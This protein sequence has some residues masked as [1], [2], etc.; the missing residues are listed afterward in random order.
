MVVK[1]LGHRTYAHSAL[2]NSPAPSV[3]SV[4]SEDEVDGGS[5][6]MEMRKWLVEWYCSGRTRLCVTGQ[7]VFTRSCPVWVVA[8]TLYDNSRVARRARVHFLVH[9][10]LMPCVQT[11]V[12]VKT[13]VSFTPS[14]S[15]GLCHTS[16]HYG[17]PWTVKRFHSNIGFVS[18][19]DVEISH[20]VL[21]I[22]GALRKDT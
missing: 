4:G 15:P 3:A 18:V 16:C 17:R 20:G 1:L 12:S 11:L 6:G 2:L 9:H 8:Y 7:G 10:S 14:S 22:L 19:L 5:M 21:N 13:I